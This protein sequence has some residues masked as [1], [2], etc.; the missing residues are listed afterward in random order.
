MK[1]ILHRECCYYANCNYC[2]QDIQF[3]SKVWIT[4]LTGTVHLCKF[5]QRVFKKKV[6]SLCDVMSQGVKFMY[7]VWNNS[8]RNGLK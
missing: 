2:D 6:Y 5:F 3:Q 7:S 4:H 8:E 1:H